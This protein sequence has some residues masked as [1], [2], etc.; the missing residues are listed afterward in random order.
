[1]FEEL[2][3]RTRTQYSSRAVRVMQSALPL[4]G[5]HSVFKA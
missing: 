4:A 2:D 3:T 5:S 1:M